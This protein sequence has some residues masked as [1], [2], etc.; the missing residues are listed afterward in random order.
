MAVAFA[1]K[2]TVIQEMFK[3]AAIYFAATFSREAS[4]HWYTGVWGRLSD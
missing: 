3:H 2:S 4:L 1:G